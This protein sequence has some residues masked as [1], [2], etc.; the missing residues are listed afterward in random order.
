VSGETIRRLGQKFGPDDARRVHRKPPRPDDIWHLDEVGIS[1]AGKKHWLWRAVDQNGYG[2]DEIV[3][4]RRNS[5][6]ARRL[7]NRLLR[8]QGRHP[9]AG[10][11]ASWAPTRGEEAGHAQGRPS[12]AEGVEH[13]GREQPCPLLPCLLQHIPFRKPERIIQH[14][15]SA[16][17]LQRLV[18]IVSA[19]RNLFVPPVQNAQHPA[20]ISI[21]PTPSPHGNPSASG[22]DESDTEILR[23][24]PELTGQRPAMTSTRRGTVSDV[25]TMTISRSISPPL[26][27]RARSL[28]DQ[29][30]TAPEGKTT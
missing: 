11:P 29:L 9:G 27:R 4:T 8:K 25:D 20:S 18:S 3:Q 7:L 22:H 30:C 23:G 12:R 15:R 6:A 17:A 14:V 28:Q 26:A 5:K 24:R 10:S 16:R 1:I 2:L 21:G 19:F 13:P